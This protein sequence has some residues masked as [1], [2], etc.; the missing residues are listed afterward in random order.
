VQV[1]DS[2]GGDGV[3]FHQIVDTMSQDIADTCS[4]GVHGSCSLCR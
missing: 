2:G 3:R 4:D 1:T